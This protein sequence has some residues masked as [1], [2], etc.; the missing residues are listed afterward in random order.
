MSLANLFAALRA[1][2][3][4]DLDACAIECADAGGLRYSWRDL[5]R[6]TAMLA[7]LVDSLELPPNSRIAVQTE[8]SV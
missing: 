7:N 8:K 5:E 3:P 4:A 2:F 6:G 1:A